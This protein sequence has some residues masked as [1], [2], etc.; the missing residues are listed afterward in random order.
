MV[1][2]RQHRDRIAWAIGNLE[3]RA[4]GDETRQ[5]VVEPGG[6]EERVVKPCKPG[7]GE[8][9]RHH[10]PG[11]DVVGTDGKLI[12]EVLAEGGRLTE[13]PHRDHVSLSV[14]VEST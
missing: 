9:V 3:E 14:E 10:V 11:D 6:H 1:E 12:G 8:V 7:R 13:A 5:L 2:E 4:G